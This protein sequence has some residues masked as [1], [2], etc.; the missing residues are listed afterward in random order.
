MQITVGYKTV[1]LLLLSHECE[2]WCLIL[3]GEHKLR[4]NEKM[5]LS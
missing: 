4:V 5:V 1:I 2:A 3:G